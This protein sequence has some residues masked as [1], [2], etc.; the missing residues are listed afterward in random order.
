VATRAAIARPRNECRPLPGLKIETGGTQASGDVEF[1]IG[2]FILVFRTS[3]ALH[4]VLS[5]ERGMRLLRFVVSHPFD[6]LQEAGSSTPL[7][8]AQNDMNGARGIEALA[9]SFSCLPSRSWLGGGR[10][11]RC[12]DR[13]RRRCAGLRW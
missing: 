5:L 12:I 10:G 2:E 3:T 7:R 11:R 1:A 4:T 6:K 8:S 9:G 13:R